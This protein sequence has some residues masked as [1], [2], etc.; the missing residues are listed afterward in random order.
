MRLTIVNL[1]MR[2]E[3]IRER[4]RS[5]GILARK[6]GELNPPYAGRRD[7]AEV[8]YRVRGVRVARRRRRP[9]ESKDP[10][11]AA[12]IALRAGG[13]LSQTIQAGGYGFL[14]SQGRR[15]A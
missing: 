10:Y 14:L 1:F 13:R 12:V 6:P 15:K 7:A 9:C 3:R 5:A 2:G 8:E 4:R 11:A